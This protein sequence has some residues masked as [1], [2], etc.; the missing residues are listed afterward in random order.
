MRKRSQDVNIRLDSEYNV[1]WSS[2]K[3]LVI[4]KRKVNI[5][6]S[7]AD[8]VLLDLYVKFRS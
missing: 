8:F 6:Q 5:L 4:D 1:Y 7:C 2:H 3:L